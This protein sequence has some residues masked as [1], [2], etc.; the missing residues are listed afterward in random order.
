MIC[1]RELD[2]GDYGALLDRLEA[3]AGYAGLRRKQLAERSA[4]KLFGVG[5]GL[6]NEHS[7][8]GAG[9]YKKRGITAIPGDDSARVRVTE[10]GRVEIYTSSAEAGQGH[11]E[12]FRLL[13]AR[14]LGVD[15]AKVDVIEGD[16]DLCPP[17]SGTFVS[18]GGVGGLSSLAEAL[19]EVAEKDLAPGLDVTR[20]VDPKQVFPTGA[21]LAVVE[22]DRVSVL[23]RVVAY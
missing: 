6:F 21:H 10:S 17:G 15:P 19:R 2:S 16:T 20:T 7:G 4:G 1:R 11:P 18:R 14:E 22:V 5:I 12:T 23:P 8:T 13:A 3:G 9:D